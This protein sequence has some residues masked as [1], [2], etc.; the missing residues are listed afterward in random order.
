MDGRSV[1]P[2]IIEELRDEDIQYPSTAT[3][4]SVQ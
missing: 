2:S 3:L 4:D 1:L